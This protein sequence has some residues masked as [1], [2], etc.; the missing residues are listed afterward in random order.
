[1]GDTV[2]YTDQKYSNSYNDSYWVGNAQSQWATGATGD[3]VFQILKARK[4]V[5]ADR[6]AC[7]DFLS[8]AI[9]E[10]RGDLA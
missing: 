1:M 4:S 9:D 10:M 3:L 2:T 7:C 8:E 5:D 6:E